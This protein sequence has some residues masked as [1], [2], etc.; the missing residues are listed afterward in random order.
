MIE[1]LCDQ[2]FLSDN[3][4]P[5]QNPEGLIKQQKIRDHLILSIKPSS[6]VLIAFLTHINNI[7]ITKCTSNWPRKPL[8]TIGGLN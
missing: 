3:Q 7:K 6:P 1:K 2:D 5:K 8:F 4:V